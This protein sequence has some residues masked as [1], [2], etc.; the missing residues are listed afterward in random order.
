MLPNFHT[1]LN[2]DDVVIVSS[3]KCPGNFFPAKIQQIIECQFLD[4]YSSKSG[5]P[6][7]IS[8]QYSLRTIDY[9]ANPFV[10]FP[11]IDTN[12]LTWEELDSFSPLDSWIESMNF[13][14]KGIIRIENSKV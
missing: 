5:K 10:D 14:M 11:G 2:F 8:Y 9:E 4:K 13:Q 6:I 3:K 7:S 12:F 1:K